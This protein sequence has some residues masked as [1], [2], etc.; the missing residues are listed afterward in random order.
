MTLINQLPYILNFLRNESWIKALNSKGN[1]YIVGGCVRDIFSERK[2]KDID[3]IV[4]GI[5]MDLIQEILK[6]YGVVDTVGKSFAVIKFRPKDFKREY[7]D[8]S[9]PRID[10]KIGNGHKGFVVETNGVSLLED[11]KRRDFT[12]NSMAV[13]ICDGELIDPFNGVSDLKNGIL[14]A[15]DSIAFAEDPLRIIRGI[16]FASRFGYKITPE[17][18]KLMRENSHLIKDISGERIFDEFIKILN[19]NG[20]I[21]IALSL[22]R[23]TYVDKALFGKKILK[24]N[25]KIKYLDPISF[26]YILGTLG[27]VHPADFLKKRLRGD[28]KLEKSV[29]ALCSILEILKNTTDEEDKRYLIFK[30]FISAPD[31]MNAVILPKEAKRIVLQMRSHEIPMKNEDISIKGGDIKKIA[32]IEEGPEIGDIKERMIRDALMNRFNWKNKEKSLEYLI[33]T[34]YSI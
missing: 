33:K 27:D 32:N 1:T 23:R 7:Y 4:E 24:Y 13:R 25:S 2:I 19:N 8:I 20:N 3:I 31:V 10:R 9:V 14:R 5:S 34:L 15:V 30:T 22:I 29:R 18:M 6:D 28:R 11:L 17:T 26:F 12:I 16:Q 21:K